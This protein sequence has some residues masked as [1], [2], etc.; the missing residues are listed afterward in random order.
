M[1][2]PVADPRPGRAAKVLGG[3]AALV[4]V[5]CCALPVLIAAG[6]VGAGAGAVVGRLPAL[7]AVL[8]V[9]AVGTRWLGRRGRSCACG[10][11]TA[12]GGGCGCRTSA[13]PLE[14]GG[15][16]RR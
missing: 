9:L 15:T 6:V 10:P 8:A 14:I 3:L 16:G 2:D 7:A 4:C 11:K 12:G 5:A 1:P 13:D